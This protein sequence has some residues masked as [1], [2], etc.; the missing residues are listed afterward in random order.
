M[1]ERGRAIVVTI[2]SNFLMRKWDFV[3]GNVI[4]S[5]ALEKA[6]HYFRRVGD[7]VDEFDLPKLEKVGF[8]E[9]G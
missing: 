9:S 5:Q 2:D 7:S 8:N 6:P 1:K 4:I 3:S